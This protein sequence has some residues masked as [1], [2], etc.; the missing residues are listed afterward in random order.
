MLPRI[1]DG[2]NGKK[3]SKAAKVYHKSICQSIFDKALAYEMEVKFNARM[4]NAFYNKGEQEMKERVAFIT[5]YS[6][7]EQAKESLVHI[8][9]MKKDREIQERYERNKAS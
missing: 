1:D 8:E 4:M 9:S 2:Y 6:K 7:F 5:A 3:P